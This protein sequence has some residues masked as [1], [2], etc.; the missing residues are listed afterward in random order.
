MP[1][2]LEWMSILALHRSSYVLLLIVVLDCYFFY[3]YRLCMDQD[4]STALMDAAGRGRHECLLIL[5]AHGAKVNK[6]DEVS[7]RGACLIAFL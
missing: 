7:V 1:L 3:R 5:L 4:G 6:A 2:F